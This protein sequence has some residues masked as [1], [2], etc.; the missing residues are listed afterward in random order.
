[1]A[2]FKYC[3]GLKDQELRISILD[4]D[5]GTDDKQIGFASLG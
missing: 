1:M 2:L 4:W 5:K 3:L